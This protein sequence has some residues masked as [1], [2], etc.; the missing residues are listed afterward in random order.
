MKQGPN[1]RRA[2]GRGVNR[3]PHGG[4]NNRSNVF[5]S[6][7]PDVRIRGN[8]FQ[9]Y[10]KYM[11]LARDASSSGDRVSMENYYQHAEHYHRIMNA[12]GED[13]EQR[14]QR[15]KRNGNWRNRR[16]T[17]EETAAAEPGEQPSEAELR[18]DANPKDAK[19][20]DAKSSESGD[21]DKA[22]G[23]DSQDSEA[24]QA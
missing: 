11:A 12:N 17:N 16:D 19:E 22:S 7:G 10:E 24:A 18:G 13:A 23:E 4:G 14:D 1:N 8:A 21:S 20:P 9:V 5:D 15:G 6:N 2:R 3:R